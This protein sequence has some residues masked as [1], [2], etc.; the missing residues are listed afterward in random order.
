MATMH[1]TFRSEFNAIHR[2]WNPK[3]SDEENQDVFGECAN[4]S[5]HGHTYGVEV[6]V[7]GDVTPARPYVTERGEIERVIREVLAPALGNA[8]LD[9]AFNRPA[10]ISTGESVAGAIWSLLEKSIPGLVAVRVVETPKNSFVRASETPGP[11]T[12]SI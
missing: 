9:V 4:P 12:A 2:L 6:T 10:F 5:G 1:L 3:L 8:N 7:R 11:M